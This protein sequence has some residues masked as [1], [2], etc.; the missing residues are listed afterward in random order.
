MK[1]L[2]RQ[3]L[4][5]ALAGLLFS[6]LVTLGPTQPVY[7][8]SPS[9]PLPTSMREISISAGS[10]HTCAILADSRVRCWG[11]NSNGQTNVPIDLQQVTQI[12]AGS[13]HTC[14]II[15]S[16]KVHCWGDS[17]KGQTTVPADLLNVAQI[18]A[19]LSHTCALMAGGVARCW[20][21]NGFGESNVPQDLGS[22][23]HISAGEEFSCALLVEGSYTCW[24]S[25]VNQQGAGSLGVSQ[26]DTR[27][28]I[29]TLRGNSV[30]CARWTANNT[31][32]VPEG[33]GTITQITV[34]F[35]HVCALSLHGA[36]G[37]WGSVDHEQEFTVPADLGQVTQISA[38]KSHTC[39][40]TAIQKV[41]CWGN[42]DYWQASVPGELGSG[43]IKQISVAE[44]TTCAVTFAG[45][46]HCWGLNA[47]GQ[48]SVPKDLGSAVSVAVGRETSCAIT[49]SGIY[50]CWGLSKALSSSGM[51]TI[52]QIDFGYSGVCAMNS[53]G[54]AFC[55]N[56]Q[57][58]GE[59]VQISA[60]YNFSNVSNYC[61]VKSD[62]YVRCW[63]SPTQDLSVPN[64]LGKVSQVDTAFGTFCAV[65]ISNTLRCWGDSKGGKTSVP[66]D[67]GQVKQVA[68]GKYHVCA[69]NLTDSVTCWGGA[70]PYFSIAALAP[71]ATPKAT[72]ISASGYS[73]SVT[74][75]NDVF[76]WGTNIYGGAEVPASFGTPL[77][78]IIKVAELKSFDLGVTLSGQAS[79]GTT[80]SAIVENSN[81]QTNLKYQWYVDESEISG[82]SSSSLKLTQSA[83]GK[84]IFVRVT[85]SEPGYITTTQVSSS[86][87]VGLGQFSLTPVPTLVG[88]GRVGS[89]ISASIGNW[90]QGTNL[91]YEWLRDGNVVSTGPSTSYKVSPSDF[92][93]KLSFKVT[94]SLSGY[95]QVSQKSLEILGIEGEFTAN[96]V[97]IV[98][99]LNKV[100]STLSAATGQWDSGVTL[101]YQWLRDGLEI[102]NQTSSKYLLSFSDLGRSVSVQVNGTMYRYLP[103]TQ[104]S[105]AVQI[106]LGEMKATQPKI[107]GQAKVGKILT[108]KTSNWAIGAKASYDW[109]LDGK[110]IKGASGKPLKLLPNHK[111]RKLSVRVTQTL[112][113]YR[114]TTLSS[115]AFKVS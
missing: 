46:V 88:S 79:V 4:F 90:D 107:V 23:R 86:A 100:G 44:S 16:G 65:S 87:T 62:G 21:G 75:T 9:T 26:I 22:I 39:A 11:D 83:L 108:L 19:G 28:A 20:G 115:S 93:C 94:A 58:L 68:V 73:C 76:C 92:G 78:D 59:V 60:G 12:S 82:A 113:G 77:G 53:M 34:G 110:P 3:S 37:C 64:D 49:A 32:K 14:A 24:G 114:T 67:L 17:S 15:S 25:N 56:P 50:R 54:T 40:V 35:A 57:N 98:S 84:K 1:F 101:S 38:G 96:P 5:I 112:A 74:L 10:H 51:G 29:C 8:A 70:S 2:R 109:L 41:R 6:S 33:F 48:A 30:S 89:T 105:R 61:A 102:P 69:I 80:I 103:A 104:K 63:S 55:S 71:L 47:E 42:N 95:S 72:Q 97:P 85:A 18:S 31:M 27:A 43:Q 45:A 52:S 99:G 106:E 81:E 91:K 66:S 13:M 111:G 7:G 36:I